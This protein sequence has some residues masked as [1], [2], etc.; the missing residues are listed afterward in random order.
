VLLGVVVVPAANVRYHHSMQLRV[1]H[2]TLP[3]S[4]QPLHFR[5]C[6]VWLAK[7]GTKKQIR[8]LS[9]A[10]VQSNASVPQSGCGSLEVVGIAT[11]CECNAWDLPD[12]VVTGGLPCSRFCFDFCGSLSASWLTV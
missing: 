11:R 12:T 3:R 8:Q 7:C 1:N 10:P 2:H 9:A 4:D 6:D 5:L